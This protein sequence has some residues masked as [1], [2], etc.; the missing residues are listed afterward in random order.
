VTVHPSF[1]LRLPDRDA[2]KA[3]HARFI[4]DLKRVKER[5]EALGLS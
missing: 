4:D 5:A 1:L 2:A 3:E